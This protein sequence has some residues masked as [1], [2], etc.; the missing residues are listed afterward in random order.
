MKHQLL[1]R[2]VE[3]IKIDTQS[4]ETSKTVPS[5]QKQFDLANLLV[6]GLEKIGVDAVELND[7]CYVYAKLNSNVPSDHPSFKRTPK[8]GFIAHLDTS[9]SVTGKNVNPQIIKAYQGGDIQ[10][11]DTFT[12]TRKENPHLKDS[13]GHTLITTDG[14]TLLGADDKAGIAII[15]TALDQLKKNASILYPDIRIGFT[16]DEEIGRGALNFNLEKF[17]A[18]FA[19]TIDGG[20]AGEINNETF[21]ADA[22]VISIKGRDIHPGEAKGI[23]INAIKVA[24]D[25]ISCLPKDLTPETTSDKAPFIHP[26]LLE[27]RVGAATIKLLLRS[28][29]NDTLKE[30]KQIL[31]DIILNV[32]K[33]YPTSLIDLEVAKT[34]RNMSD[35][36]KKVPHVSQYLEEAVKKTGLEPRWIPVRGGTDG[37]GLTAMGLPCPNI[38]T[39]GHN[40]HGQTE[41]ISLDIMEKSVETILNLVQIVVDKA[42]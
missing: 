12:L 1:S 41:W 20:P 6:T 28:F 3:Y 33:K 8:I 25:I 10:L 32:Q 40:Y 36:L 42:K 31:K 39:G 21:S 18:D 13:F 4:D 29:D 16:P 17:D 22:A 34:Y 7:H 11:N 27:G 37:S 2:F 5:T 38:F 15:M 24:S 9:P 35:E 26:H 23:M 30:Q 19:Y 14:T